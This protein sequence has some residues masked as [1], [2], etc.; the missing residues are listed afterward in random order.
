[1][2]VYRMTS[3]PPRACCVFLKSCSGRGGWAGRAKMGELLMGERSRDRERRSA[4]ANT[5]CG[6][7]ARGW[8]ESAVAPLALVVAA[9]LFAT[10]SGCWLIPLG[11][12]SPQSEVVPQQLHDERAVLI[13]VLVEGV[14][15]SDGVIKGLWE[16]PERN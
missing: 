8:L 5:F 1:M 3:G 9:V 10:I 15:L 12:R 7:T 14:Q 11:V 13:G 6:R 2:W 4:R 16:T